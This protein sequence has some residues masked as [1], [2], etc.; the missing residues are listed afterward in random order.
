MNRFPMPG[1]EDILADHD[2]VLSTSTAL[3]FMTED[4]LRWRITVGRLLESRSGHGLPHPDSSVVER[5]VGFGFELLKLPDIP[6]GSQGN[7]GGREG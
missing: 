4:Q 5:G 2:G 3:K 1:F 6:G 7:F